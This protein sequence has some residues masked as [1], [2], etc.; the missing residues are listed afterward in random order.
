MLFISAE[1]ISDKSI[2]VHLN[3]RSCNT[4]L[5]RHLFGTHA[6]ISFQL[7]RLKYLL[8]RFLQTLHFFCS[9]SNPTPVLSKLINETSYWITL[10]KYS[11]KVFFPRHNLQ[12]ISFVNTS[13][14]FLTSGVH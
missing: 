13:F 6:Y 2:N 1:R 11:F 12:S 5:W 14:N 4:R 9:R 8:K 3:Y 10:D 7:Q